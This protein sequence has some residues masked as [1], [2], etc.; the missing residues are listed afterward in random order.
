MAKV[1]MIIVGGFLGAGK[2]TLL[3]KAAQ[4]LAQRG[5]KVGLITNDQAANLV[6]TGVLRQAGQE[7]KEVA[8]ACFCCAFN[9]LLFV[10]DE[11]IASFGPDV[12]IGEPVGSCTDLSATVLQPM[13]KLCRDT[14][15]LAPFTVLIDPAEFLRNICGDASAVESVR[16]IYRKQIEEAD[17]LVVNK[18]DTLSPEALA[19]VQSLIRREFPGIPARTMSAA[20]GGGVGGWLDAILAGGNAGERIA[21]VDYDTYADGEAA[22]GWLNAALTLTAPG[23]I[24]WKAFGADL[25]TRMRTRLTAA[26]ARIAHLKILLASEGGKLK[27]SLTSNVGE[28]SVEGAASAGGRATLVVN[29]R[30]Q[31][32]P[33]DLKAIVERCI[34][35]A[36]GKSI[37]AVI[38]E[39]TS[40]RPSRP[41]P[42]HR[43]GSVV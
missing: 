17:L 39:I 43:F 1:K 27:M 28:V 29:A 34:Q 15:D 18:V 4:K 36:A 12:I 24:N 42:V 3:A 13:K 38:V 5:L 40:F 23:P 6:D 35:E 19:Q 26:A 33:A 41:N 14:F 16:Y 7:V 37:S 11:L 31:A 9:R 10:C 22:L 8:G 21:Q 25:M 30:V 32:D 20:D 2:T